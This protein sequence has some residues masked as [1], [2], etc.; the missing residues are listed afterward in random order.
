MEAVRTEAQQV[1]PAA[2]LGVQAALRVRAE[3]YLAVEVEGV[4]I[5]LMSG[6]REQQER[7]LLPNI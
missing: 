6:A 2:E 3:Q 5:T 1:V 4:W 7:W